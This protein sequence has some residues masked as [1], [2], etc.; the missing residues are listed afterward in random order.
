LAFHREW[1]RSGPRTVRGAVGNGG[2]LEKDG[3]TIL[4]SYG[5]DAL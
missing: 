1:T 4:H 3:S 2:T 5:I